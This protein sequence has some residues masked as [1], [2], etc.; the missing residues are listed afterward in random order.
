MQLANNKLTYD[1]IDTIDMDETAPPVVD[2]PILC[3]REF[4]EQSINRLM[5]RLYA[6]SLRFTRN[7]SDAEDLMA[8]S[9]LKAWKSFGSLDDRSKFDGWMMRIVSNTYISRWRRSK[10][11]DKIFD[12]ELCTS[13]IDDTQLLYARLHQPFLLWFGTPEQTFVN[14]L[15][16][17]DIEKALDTLSDGYRLV[18]HMIEIMGFTYEETAE[19]LEVPVGTVRSRL[20]RGRRQLQVALWQHAQDA[21]LVTD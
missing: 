1:Y 17:E 9:M 13:D 6:T 16:R 7:K 21:S 14:S 19:S 10:S 11:Y 15:L 18:V 2:E 3:D 4:F 5:D 20:N 12:D 8:D